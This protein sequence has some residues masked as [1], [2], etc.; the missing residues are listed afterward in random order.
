MITWTLFLDTIEFGYT[1]LTT[2][3]TKIVDEILFRL[4]RENNKSSQDE[5][6]IKILKDILAQS[7]NNS[8]TIST[9]KTRQVVNREIKI[10][11]KGSD[12]ELLKKLNSTNKGNP[13]TSLKPKA[14]MT[15]KSYAAF[16]SIFNFF[17]L[18]NNEKIGES[19][20]GD[21]TEAYYYYTI[22]IN[23]EICLL[24]ICVFVLVLI[25]FSVLSCLYRCLSP[26]RKD[27]YYYC[28][29]HQYG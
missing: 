19:K 6:S 29:Y 16:D 15:E 26:S 20:I 27:N 22:K 12:S 23:K 28:K 24:L 9:N 3:K 1:Q 13:S 17:N 18:N 10:I 25:A 14:N 11:Y 7:F 21:I 8:S 5:I 4:S 2:P